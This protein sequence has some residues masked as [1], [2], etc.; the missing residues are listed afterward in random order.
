M[1][2]TVDRALANAIV[3]DPDTVAE[4]LDDLVARTG[5]DELLV[6]SSTHDRDAQADS[7][8][9]LARLLGAGR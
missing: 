7:D 2:M 3:G 4:R 6:F 8:A 9:A 5:A 1:R